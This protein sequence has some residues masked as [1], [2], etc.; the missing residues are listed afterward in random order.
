MNQII[1]PIK[2][3]LC[4]CLVL[5][6]IL[7]GCG[8]KES[9][10]PTASD[11][12]KLSTAAGF[13]AAK[14]EEDEGFIAGKDGNNKTQNYAYLYDNAVA[15][16]ALSHAGAYWHMQMIADAIVFAQN[17]DRAFN[18]GRLRNAYISGNPKSDSGWSII[19]GEVT[20]RLPGFWKDGKW[21][22]D[23]YAVSTSSGNMAWVILALCTAAKNSPSEKA[24]EY[25]EAAVKAADFVLTLKSDTGGF[26]AG[27]KGWDDN[28]EKVNYKST[29]HNI[30]LICAFRALA[31][32]IYEDNPT[33]A[34][35]Y[36]SAANHAEEF[37]FSMYDDELKCF[38]TGTEADGETI[39][40]GVIPLD[41]NSLAIM[42][43]NDK[44]DNAYDIISYVEDMMTVGDG[45]DFSA[46]DLDGIWNEGTAQMA[47]CYLIVNADEKYDAIIDY[48]K[49]QEYK[50]GSI[51]AADRDGVSTGFVVSGSNVLWEYNNTQSIG[52]TGWYAFAQMKVNPL[53]IGE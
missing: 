6:L 40:E 17:H 23:A 19:A 38:Y 33:K 50:D 51:P 15:V 22:E 46:G 32:L 26:T 43:L 24:L 9:D 39:S 29:E 41:T 34:K 35:E 4:K 27:Y 8:T 31:S 18:D 5:M 16:I 30:D 37:V 45:F 10:I 21:Q 53:D 11:I 44:I 13:L 42:A 20:I 49:T 25:T 14:V 3:V 1:N 36:Q 52:A 47:I 48:L 7:S 28:Q 12:S 2:K